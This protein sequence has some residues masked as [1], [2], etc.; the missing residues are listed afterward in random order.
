M[1]C[2]GCLHYKNRHKLRLEFQWLSNY[3]VDLQFNSNVFETK[4][5]VDNFV[6]CQTYGLK[7]T[8]QKRIKIHIMKHL[9]STIRSDENDS[10]AHIMTTLKLYCTHVVGFGGR[11][12]QPRGSGDGRR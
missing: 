4:I 10:D 3:N 9:E 6:L 7:D 8:R 5:L 11:V 1:N 12:Q 2:V